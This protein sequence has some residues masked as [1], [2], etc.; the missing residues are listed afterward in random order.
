MGKDKLEKAQVGTSIPKPTNPKA[1]LDEGFMEQRYGGYRQ[2]TGLPSPNAGSVVAKSYGDSGEGQPGA[3]STFIKELADT[4]SSKGRG[5]K[6]RT[7]DQYIGSDRYD[8]FNADPGWDNEDAAAQGQGWASKMVNGVGKGL[9]LTGTTFLQNT[10]GLVNGVIQASVDGRFASFYDNDFNN[11]LDEFNKGL[12]DSLPNYYTAAERDAEWYSPTYWAKG[13]FLWDGVVKNMGFAA[14]TYLS[15]GVYTSALKGIPLASKLFST[16]KAAET[17]AATEAGLA[18]GKGAAGIYG[19][20]KSLSDTF[21]KTANGYNTL[22]KGQ[23]VLVAG[24]STTGEAGF[25]AL[26]NA[27]E[28]R[29]GLISQYKL[30]FGI[31]PTAE[32]LDDIN[33]A[34]DAAANRAMVANMA[35]LTATNYIQLPK[36]FQS[37]YNSEKTL[38]NGLGREI[39]DVSLDAAGVMSK[40]KVSKLGRVV[41]AIRKPYLFS[42]SEALEESSQYGIGEATKDYY[43]KAYNG[44]ATNWMSSIKAG[45]DSMVSDEGA[46]N[47]LIGGLSGSIMMNIAPSVRSLLGGPKTQ[48]QRIRQNTDDFV[49]AFNKTNLGDAINA[50]QFDLSNFTKETGEAVNRGTVI[51]QERERALKNGEIFESKNLESDYIINYLT[52]RIKYGRFDLIKSEIEEYRTLAGTDAGF[53]QLVKEGK[54]LTTDTRES[55]LARINRFSEVADSAQ[56]LYQSLNL[57]FGA[58]FKT[59]DLGDVIE[60]EKGNPI[61]E[62]PPSV[63]NQMMYTALKTEDFDQRILNL[64]GKLS[65]A[66]INTQAVLQSVIDGDFKAYNEAVVQLKE[67][68]MIGSKKDQ[69]GSYL[70]DIA[71]AASQRQNFIKTYDDIKE[72]PSK[73]TSEPVIVKD[74]VEEEEVETIKV[75]TEKG[76]KDVAVETEYFVGNSVDYNEDGLDELFKI[77]TLIV[78]GYNEDGTLKIVNTKT[79]EERDLKRGT[80]NKLKLGKVSSVKNN[81]AANW[82]YNHRNEIF[83]LNRGKNFGGYVDGRIEY[84]AVNNDTGKIYFVYKTNGGKIKR[85]Q[86]DNSFLVPQKGF[87]QPRL[88]AV[89]SVQSKNQKDSFKKY[90]SAAEIQKQRKRL[91][92]NREARLEVLSQLGEEGK[93]NIVELNKQIEKAASDLAKVK[94]DLANI[95]KM[96]KAGPTGPKIK[97]NFS[98]A[99]KSFTRTINKLTQMRKDLNK[100]LKL[101]EAERDEVLSDISYFEQYANEISDAPEDS[102]EFLQELKDQVKLLAD[103][104]KNLAKIIKAAKKMGTTLRQVTKKAASLFRKAI[105]STYIVGDDY[106]QALD[107]LLDDVAAGENLDVTWPALKEEIVNFKL[108]ND[109]SKDVNLNESDIVKTQDEVAKLTTDINELRNEYRA[110]KII[111]DRFQSI[112]NEYNAKKAAQEKLANDQRLLDRIFATGIKAPALNEY[113]GAYN[114]DSKKSTEILPVATIPNDDEGEDYQIRSNAFG[115]NLNSF[116]NRDEIRGIY[117]TSAIEDQLLPGVIDKMLSGGKTPLSE[118]QKEKFKETMIVM[119]MVNENG[120]LVNVN[121]QPIAEDEDNLDNAIYQAMPEAGLTNTK[122]SMFRENTPDEVVDSIKQQY[123]EFRESVLAQDAL[124]IPQ[125]IEASFGTPEYEKNDAGDRIYTTITSVQD[126]GLVTEDELES[127]ILIKIPTSKGSLSEGTTSYDSPVGR[128][129]LRLKNAY[130]PLKNRKHTEEEATVIYQSILE[131]SKNIEKGQ[132]LESDASIDILNFLRRVTY[133]GIPIDNAGERKEPGRNSVF[134]ERTTPEAGG[135]LQFAKLQLTIGR[136]PDAKF[137]FSPTELEMSKDVIITL[138]QNTYNNI[139]AYDKILDNIDAEFQQITGIENGEIQSVTWDNYQTYLLSNT[140]P[141]GSKRPNSDLPLH[142]MMKPKV[143]GEVNRNNIYF[144]SKTGQDNYTIPN[145]SSQAPKEL[146]IKD[147]KIKAP[148]ADTG[149]YVLDGETTDVYTSPGGATLNFRFDKKATEPSWDQVAVLQGGDLEAVVEKIKGNEK[150]PKDVTE[151]ELKSFIGEQLKRTIFKSIEKVLP[152]RKAKVAFESSIV[153][154]DSEVEAGQALG[155]L[156]DDAPAPAP[157][158]PAQP[159]QQTSEVEVVTYKGTKYSVDFN[160]GSGT[161]TNLKTGK[162]LEGG[163]TSPVGQAV[164]DLAIYQQDSTQQAS[165]VVITDDTPSG[166]GLNFQDDIDDAIADMN[167]EHFREVIEGELELAKTENWNEVKSW[168]NK[169]L[170]Q[171][172]LNIVKN[173]IEAG[174]GRK[175]WGMYKDRAIYVYENAE[176]GTTYHEAFEAVFNGM[177]STEDKTKLRKEFNS[178]KG[179][180]V[181]R[182]TGETVKFSEATGQQIKEQLAE[183]FRDYIQEDIKPKG[184]FARMFKKL[185]DLIE[186]WFM[187]PSSDTFTKELFDKINT[188]GFAN[189]LVLDFS[190][191]GVTFLPSQFDSN[192]AFAVNFQDEISSP[193][194]YRDPFV[195]EPEYRLVALDDQQ[196]Y[197]TLQEMTYQL[198]TDALKNDTDLFNLTLLKGNETETY[199]KILKNVLR[200]AQQKG[201]VATKYMNLSKSAKAK[202]EK[203]FQWGAKTRDV[204]TNEEM[205]RLNISIFQNKKLKN[206]IVETWPLLIDKHKQYL[207]SFNVSFDQSAQEQLEDNDRIRESNKF[208]ASKIDSLKAASSTLKLLL[209]TLQIKNNQG[210]PE[211][212]TINGSVLQPIGKTYVTLMTK[213]HGSPN[214]DDAMLKLKELAQEYPTYAPLYA[215]ITGD[216]VGTEGVSFNN[217]SLDQSRLVTAMWRTFHKMTPE[218]LNTYIYKDG[219]TVGPAAY[220][221]AADQLTRN[222]INDISTLSK[223]DKGLFNYNKVTGKYT[224]KKAAITNAP[225]NTPIAMSNFLKRLGISFSEVEIRKL[226]RIGKKEKIK[227]VVSKVRDSLAGIK[228]VTTF[229]KDSLDINRRLKELAFLQTLA[230][231][232]EY[233]STYYNVNGERV[234][235]AFGGNAANDLYVALKNAKKKEDLAGTPFEYLL[236]D[237]FSQGSSIMSRMFTS[238]GI[239]KPGAENLF[240]PGIAGGIVYDGKKSNKSSSRLTA[241]E[242]YIQELNF[243]LAGEFMNLVPGDASLEHTLYMGNPVDQSQLSKTGVARVISNIF[244]PYLLSEINLSRDNRPI[245]E[246][247]YEKDTPEFEKRKTTDLRFFKGILGEDLHNKIINETGSPEDVYNIY[248]ND[249]NKA[250]S[251]YIKKWVSRNQTM[252]T[253]YGMIQV[254]GSLEATYTIPEVAL[255][256]N[257]KADQFNRSL[258]ALGI[259]Y[260]IA[261]IEMHKLLYS[262]PYQY[263]DELKRTKSFLSPRQTLVNN[264]PMFQ[265]QQNKLWNKGYESTNDIG[266]YSFTKDH[267]VTATHNDVIGA[268]DLPGYKP[269]EETDGA[270]IISFPAYRALRINADNWNAAEEK[271][272]RYDI[273]W[274]KR[275]KSIKRSPEESALL[276]EGNPSV[277]SAYPDQKPIVS[278][279]KLDKS[280]NNSSYNNVVLDKNSLYPLSYR[281]MKELNADNGVKLYNKMQKEGIDYIAFKSARKVGAESLHSTYNDDGSFNTDEYTNKILVPYSIMGIQSEIP[282]KEVSLV[283]RGSQTTKLITLDMFDNGVPIDFKQFI[284]EGELSR[285]KQW[286]KLS[287]LE[288]KDQSDIYSEAIKNTEILEALTEDA[289]QRVLRRLGISET[290]QGYEITNMSEAT[291]TLRSELFKREVNDN[292][293]IALEQ[294]ET[295]GVALEITPAYQQ[296][297]NIL[298]SIINKELVRSKISGG[299]KT[300]IPSTLFE[301]TRAKFNKKLNGHTSDILKFYEDKDGK[302]VME[303]GVGRWFNSNMSDKDL[304]NYLNKTENKSILEGLA[305]RIPTQAQNSID[306]IRVGMIL[307]KEFGDN[308]VV[309][310]AIVE[311]VG[312]DFDIDKLSIYLKNVIYIN[313]ELKEVPFFGTGTDSKRKIA[314]LFD[315]GKLFNAA[316]KKQLDALGQLKSW[317]VQ[318]LIN[319]D[320]AIENNPNDKYGD[321]LAQ[322]GVVDQEDSLET[323][324]NEL[325]EIGVRDAIVNKLYKQSLENGFIDSSRKLASH[326]LNFEKLIRPNSADYLKDLAKRVVSKT[327]GQAFNYTKVD[328]MLDNRFMLSLRQAF[329]SGKKAIGIDAISQTGLSL[330]QKSIIT[331]DT[332]RLSSLSKEDQDWL[333]DG[334]IAFKN[335]NTYEG[336]ASLSGIYNADGQLISN[337]NSQLM[338]GHVDISKGPWIMELGATPQLAPTILFLNGIGVPIDQIIFFVNQP[339]IRTYLSAL[340]N[341]GK[342]WLFNPDIYQETI[343]QY[344]G[345]VRTG[346]NIDFVIPSAEVLEKTMSSAS[347]IKS[348]QPQYLKEFLKYARM[349]GQYYKF[350][351]G[352]NFDTAVLN[353]HFLVF[354]K[355]IQYKEAQDSLIAGAESRL[356]DTWL[357]NLA[358]R[359]GITENYSPTGRGNTRDAVAS[360]LLSDRGNVRRVLETIL[361]PHINKSDKQFIK[362]ARKAVN[363]LI[364]W[365]VQTRGLNTQLQKVLL[366]TTGTSAQALELVNKIKTAKKGSPYYTMRNNLVVNNLQAMPARSAG[367]L[368]NNLKLNSLG[369]KAYDVNSVIFSFR[370]LK[371]FLQSMGQSNLYDD[372][373]KLSVLQS[374]LANS[375]I[376]FT[377]YLPYEDV[378]SLYKYTLRILDNMPNLQDFAD[379]NMFERNGW[380]DSDIVSSDSLYMI[381]PSNSNAKGVS[382]PAIAP[383]ARPASVN[384]AF[385]DGEIPLTVT[386]DVRYFKPGDDIISYN[387]NDLE[388]SRIERN[389]KRKEGDYSYIKKGLFKRVMDQGEP[390]V[391]YNPKTKKNYYI[392]KAINGLGD[393]FRAQEYYATASRSKI[394]NQLIKVKEVSD[395]T[396]VA[397]WQGA[398]DIKYPSTEEGG[399]IMAKLNDGKILLADGE[400]YIPEEITAKLLEEIGYSK[401]SANIILTLK[402]KG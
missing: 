295:K 222:Y 204:L 385:R 259:N 5:P 264:S 215:R 209:A 352:T 195:T 221:S 117:L 304:L 76:I 143:E 324:I 152:K 20:L 178:R 121:G 44:E 132:G 369:T 26:H 29:E 198:V 194:D 347:K 73:Y 141:D 216:S 219:V 36:I 169:N 182:P 237:V 60:D 184:L 18:G 376:S 335:Y 252:M 220:S 13:N 356:N 296:V 318:G 291:K 224:P 245:P 148:V 298:Y 400:K 355:Q 75:Q 283:T 103:N 111:L 164:V 197:D 131:L 100:T 41:N 186:K 89:G 399:A 189:N 112:M 384:N 358:S 120:D 144:F 389:Q 287:L 351:N 180:F 39:G 145:P 172:P 68:D 27:N 236:T 260:M 19:E 115:A 329:V 66:G 257:M 97:L 94:E 192:F 353:D 105:K 316:Q 173:I 292:I 274:E 354:K 289:Y 52:P 196:M 280:G 312:S 59:N 28:F 88:K 229:S 386:Q 81:S 327:K 308:V 80:F 96:K 321:L 368:P 339:S 396:V 256:E 271:Q 301:K 166:G 85:K 67:S 150:A 205:S 322:L 43:Q 276:T 78:K 161:I 58:K 362:I 265:A 379:I 54:A 154:G 210:K 46:K 37:S 346:T 313:N 1:M 258:T 122:G 282:S 233:D 65:A 238:K 334:K 133:W 102:G 40:T 269:Y 272:Y 45:L 62:Y 202:G 168:M 33:R 359:L 357:G 323:F 349:S 42:Y 107:K 338:D 328:N 395:E 305:F 248:I 206:N 14:G 124:G 364:D 279:S 63:M 255:K 38:L 201:N 191:E 136:S 134:F 51:Q 227:D 83:R 246:V 139:N 84:E 302:R 277:K 4:P 337:I 365:G 382:Y 290:N 156:F 137:D 341:E 239:K 50:M 9:A 380:T 281:V 140:N 299:Q 82:F 284:G 344:G 319:N 95:R 200:V 249:I 165:E 242:R 309:P 155:S 71:D 30:D 306:V 311:K 394:D 261:N 286:E 157:K 381:T 330:N 243:N 49:T 278:G 130:V 345:L 325:S 135:S 22:N 32:A 370:S 104:S 342:T 378:A 253:R 118:E 74:Q 398:L 393:G 212:S 391:Y 151:E 275:D 315:S 183:E 91:K 21:L 142:T 86:I 15:A 77:G 207:Q 343:D 317:E 109:I 350:T 294:F 108:T 263:K 226:Y 116:E 363:S 119:V 11:A 34:T 387:W 53:D 235:T 170:P 101:A 270:S 326:P 158:A 64:G 361:L 106:A 23:R 217:L 366:D 24:L 174:G 56:S 70:D 3:L 374:G 25:E 69:L 285:E 232:P 251:V 160:V 244:K 267:F 176:V 146:I 388:I 331:I 153:V 211:I 332:D 128:A 99:T 72:N 390:L 113:E 348:N 402:C 185:K 303:I 92:Q 262:D 149:G 250:I 375:P 266:Y 214:V 8:Y 336:K 247:E 79:G 127:E 177:L 360:F 125:I 401:K 310:S 126:A 288:K 163:V 159:T 55:Y 373:V 208:D 187:S 199:N 241:R 240:R 171:V 231:N 175:A 234:Q 90:T 162:V 138:L 392:Y 228:S 372:I 93:E 31:V 179:T 114:P 300:Q 314:D 123:K 188:G 397:A 230:S 367:N 203:Q 6:M 17:I 190:Y 218:A 254:G 61:L 98:K 223:S 383:W 307:P 297:R 167:D 371:K 47:A 181:D 225:L 2:S 12:E 129:F 10:V 293:S 57:R 147:G 273:A 333:G 213:L 268:V 48:K 320:A 35:L 377:S 193:I 340:E 7:A 87:N 110:R 16:G